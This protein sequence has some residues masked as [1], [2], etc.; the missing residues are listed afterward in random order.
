MT[1]PEVV[2]GAL[3]GLGSLTFFVLIAYHDAISTRISGGR[4]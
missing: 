2:A 1:W 4:R 3:T